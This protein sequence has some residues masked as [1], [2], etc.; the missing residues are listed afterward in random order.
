MASVE[1]LQEAV[2]MLVAERQALH[3]RNAGATNSSRT[4]SSSP[5]GNSSTPTLIDRCL[6]HAEPNAA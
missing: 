5:A 6:R 2:S 1:C 4:G 3:D